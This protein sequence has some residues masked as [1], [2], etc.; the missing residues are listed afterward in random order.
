[1]GVV[2]MVGSLEMRVV[3]VRAAAVWRISRRV[4]MAFYF[5]SVCDG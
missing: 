5:F 4:G 1:M 2:G 3:A